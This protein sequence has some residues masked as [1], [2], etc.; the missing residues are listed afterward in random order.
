MAL[1]EKARDFGAADPVSGSG[2][3]VVL[4]VIIRMAD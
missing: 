3:N 2:K 4:F 1:L